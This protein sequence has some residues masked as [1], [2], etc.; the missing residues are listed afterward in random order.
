MYVRET[1]QKRADGSVLTHLQLVRS[2]WD[3][4]KKRSITKVLA[5]FGRAEDPATLTRLR[6]LA[7]SIQRHTDPEALVVQPGW[8]L[9]DA[10]PHGPL[11]V[12]EA[13]WRELGLR[14]AFRRIRAGRKLGYDLERAVFA[15]VANR[16]CAPAS[17]LYCFEQ[18]LREDVRLAGAAQLELQ[19]LYRAMD[20]VEQRLDAIEESLFNRLAN[21]LNLDVELVFYDTTSLHFETD[22]EDEGE[23]PLRKRGHSKNKR[24]DL[25]QVVIGLA[26]TR[27]GFPIRHWVFPGNTVDVT[28]VARV[29]EDLRGWKLSR[30]VFVGDAGMVSKDNLRTLALGGGRYIVGMPMR[31]GDRISDEVI[32]RAGRYRE[33]ASNLAVK[34]V[35]LGEGERRQRYVVCRN[36]DEAERQRRHREKLVRTLEAELASLADL[37]ADAHSARVCQLV[38]SRRYGRYLRQTRGGKPK[39][40]KKALREAER[41]DGKFVI[42]SN[43]DSL[44][45]ADLALGY[46][47]LLRV[48]NAWRTMKS[49]L[50]MRPVH[51][52]AP[53]R[54]RAHIALT[55][56]ALL[57]QRVAEVRCEDTWR[58]I[59]D[60]LRQIKLAR[61]STP[62]GDVWQVTDPRPAAQKR[63]RKLGLK[64]P[65]VV[66]KPVR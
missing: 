36:Q 2:V 22:E 4:A 18:W 55:V 45:G 31:R 1:R 20:V 30:C 37:G 6:R 25:P 53:R 49:G 61:L 15:M 11:Y 38:A 33:V 46:K 40:N 48:E 43:D 51:H 35:V 26:V 13:L 52:Y 24:G 62:D 58:N 8:K 39:L 7:A 64:N 44:T 28:T 9:V 12:L 54:I 63:L 34:E 27:D 21:L 3:P 14:D 66:V 32:G 57:L 16:A 65:P 5:G 60:D 41:Y 19:H 59:R 23:A 10:W 42:T 50:R 29:K 17:K 56:W 47:Q